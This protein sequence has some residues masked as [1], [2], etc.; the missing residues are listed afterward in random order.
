MTTDQPAD[1]RQIEAW[2]EEIVADPSVLPDGVALVQSRLVR[3]VG[4]ATLPSGVEVY[5]K[6]MGF[7]RGKDRLRYLLRPLPAMHEGMIFRY[8][9]TTETC[10][11]R[12]PIA[13]AEENIPGERK[14]SC[15]SW[16][17]RLGSTTGSTALAQESRAHH[18]T[19]RRH[20][21]HRQLMQTSGCTSAILLHPVRQSPLTCRGRNDITRLRILS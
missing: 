17:N 3:A 5:L 9:A 15:R 18:R 14:T 6:I 12:L 2:W 21:Y 4:R 20:C 16:D 11:T 1:R 13:V 8:P 7:P 19:K 10:F